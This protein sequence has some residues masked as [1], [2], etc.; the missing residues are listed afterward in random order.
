[1]KKY[2]GLD[3]HTKETVMCVFEPATDTK[4]FARMRSDVEEVA[5]RIR[6]ERC[7]GDRLYVTFETGPQAGL[8]YDRLVNE[9]DEV[10][11]SNPSQ[12]AWIYRTRKKTDRIDAEKQARLL[13]LREIPAV[14]M[15][16]KDV[17][18]WR[19]VIQHRRGLVGDQTRCKNR[20]RHHLKAQGER[21]ACSGSWWNQ[22]NR[23]W[24][25]SITERD[26]RPW[27]RSLRDL[28][29]QLA[30]LE[31]QVKRVTRRLDEYSSR[32]PRILLLR[33]I[34]GVGPRTAESVVAYT[35]DVHRF[36]SSKRF[37]S[38]F[39]VTPKLDESAGTRRLG[40]ISKRGP[41]VVRWH[42]TESSWRATMRSPALREFYRR[43]QHGQKGRRKVALIAVVRKILTIMYAMLKSGEIFNEDLVLRQVT[44]A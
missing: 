41:S 39:G 3:I 22:A 34:P 17:R 11:V 14:R 32:D 31:E 1:M 37:A 20:I 36:R 38:Y 2:I 40:H 44:Q 19:A 33:T 21:K 35:D 28:L 42:L 43:V 10:T 24:M 8:F 18:E 23:A 12:M 6:R 9:A 5:K 15:P 16:T 25:R 27:H 30:M 13:Y 26:E 4:R 29:D 7:N